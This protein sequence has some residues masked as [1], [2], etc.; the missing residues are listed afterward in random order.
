MEQKYFTTLILVVLRVSR[1]IDVLGDT[2]VQLP[3]SDNLSFIDIFPG[4]FKKR[5]RWQTKSQIGIRFVRK[6]GKGR[7]KCYTTNAVYRSVP[8]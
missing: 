7:R 3:A 6:K 5:Y 1:F 4:I 2:L 8:D